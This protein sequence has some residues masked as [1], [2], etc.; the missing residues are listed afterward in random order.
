MFTLTAPKGLSELG[1]S[2]VPA[3]TVLIMVIRVTNGAS[4][5]H[6]LLSVT[7]PPSTESLPLIQL[8]LVKD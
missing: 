7:L 2:S 6:S 3:L 4:E 8:T 5:A 1:P